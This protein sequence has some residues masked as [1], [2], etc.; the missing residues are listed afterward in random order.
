MQTLQTNINA[1]LQRRV[2]KQKMERT[3]QKRNREEETVPVIN[4]L[5]AYTKARPRFPS[6]PATRAPQAPCTPLCHSHLSQ[7][8]SWPASARQP[9]LT[10]D[11]ITL[12]CYPPRLHGRCSPRAGTLHNPLT[13]R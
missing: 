3:L 9:C 11:P 5:Q 10:D 12:P 13:A 8:G 4:T 2:A 1:K 6:S 7:K